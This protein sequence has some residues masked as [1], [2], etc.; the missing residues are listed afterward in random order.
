V[1]RDFRLSFDPFALVRSRATPSQGA[2]ASAKARRR[3]VLGAFKVPDPARVK[4]KN[5]LLLDDVMTTGATVQACA[6]ALKRAGVARVHVLALAR[7]VKA[8][9][10]II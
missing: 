7:V 10:M 2:T 8:S 9:D 5:V 3:N 6:R 4:G 1:A